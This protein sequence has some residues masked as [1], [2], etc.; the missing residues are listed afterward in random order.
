MLNISNSKIL[1]YNRRNIAQTVFCCKP[2]TKLAQKLDGSQ[3]TISSD[4]STTEDA[5]LDFEDFQKAFRAKSTSE[6]IRALL[7]YKICSIDSLVGNNQKLIQISRKLLG[8]TGFELLMK[9]T[10]YGHFVAGETQPAIKDKLSLMEKYGVGAILDYAVEADI[11]KEISESIEDAEDT[12]VY[13]LY[14]VKH[15]YQAHSKFLDRRKQVV[16][17]RTYFY[18]GEEKCDENMKIFLDC[19]ETTGATATNGF[20]AIKVTALGRPALLLRVSQI[21]NQVRAYF[22]QLATE[23][24]EMLSES[25]I[26]ESCFYDALQQLGVDMTEDEAHEIFKII[27]VNKS[28]GIDYV[29]W[30]SFLTP[31]LQLSKLFRAKPKQH[32]VKGEE[33]ILSLTEQELKEMDN[34]THRMFTIAKLA[35]EKGVRLM[36]DAEQTYFQPAITRITLDAMRVFNKESPVIFNTYQCYQKDAPNLVDV[37]LEF[38]R[39]EG[40]CFAAKLVRGAYM[41]QE[42]MRASELNYPDPIHDTISDTNNCYNQLLTTV[43]HEVKERKA[44]VMVASHNEESVRHTITTMKQLDIQ[45]DDDKVFFGQLL[46]MCDVITYALG[47]GGY[48][49]Y[50]YVPYGPVE[51]VMPYLSRRAME[52]R[53]LMKGVVKER[54]MLW[55]ELVRRRKQRQLNHNPN[56][57]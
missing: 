57:S 52:N 15:R 25:E 5:V 50:K 47:S 26:A 8:K 55:S 31:Q 37:D 1:L 35:K 29:E 46:G 12:F 20:A 39:R 19:I 13:D 3:A 24:A 22:D 38:S 51:E 17:A 23:K 44:N 34:L 33:I 14:D 9:N 16:S 45:P 2:V 54:N 53:S 11:P 21:I 41:E 42:R 49:A 40:F 43:L 48:A 36:V 32:G 18:E 28:G 7:V 6:I 30:N 4:S 56:L 27:D 10:F